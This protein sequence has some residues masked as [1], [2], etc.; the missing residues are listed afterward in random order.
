M[1]G[2]WLRLMMVPDLR[3]MGIEDL[4]EMPWG[5]HLCAFYESEDD[6]L[7]LLLPYFR[8]GLRNDEFCMYIASQ[9]LDRERTEEG[10]RGEGLGRYLDR[11]QMQIIPREEWYLKGGIFDAQRVLKGWTRKCEEGAARGYDGVRVM[12][13]MAWLDKV[14]WRSLA[15]YEALV[16]RRLFNGHRMIAVC[17]YPLDRCDERRATDLVATHEF[18]LVRN[19]DEWAAIRPTQKQGAVGRVLELR[20]ES[21]DLDGLLVEGRLE[22][23]IAGMLRDLEDSF[24]GGSLWRRSLASCN[25][26]RNL[27][28]EIRTW[29]QGQLE[30]IARE[31]DEIQS[32]TGSLARMHRKMSGARYVRARAESGGVAMEVEG[33]RGFDGCETRTSRGNVF[34]CVP[35]MAVAAMLQRAADT[36]VWVDV[37]G[38]DRVCRIGLHPAWILECLRELEPFDLDGLVVLRGGRVLFSHVPSD[39]EAEALNEAVLLDEERPVETEAIRLEELDRGTKKVLMARLGDSLIS[40]CIGGDAPTE[41]LRAHLARAITLMASF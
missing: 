8:A 33:C 7:D 18:E 41:G 3:E 23:A 21:D 39:S 34:R 14:D 30:Q 19:P 6:L 22:R 32:L 16:N 11:G 27:C 17:S 2:R 24:G 12:G 37:A 36:P 20:D 35:V 10:M 25:A 15:A 40:I 5:T 31:R 13:N 1:V 9:P 29:A 38:D 28:D 26:N 4:G